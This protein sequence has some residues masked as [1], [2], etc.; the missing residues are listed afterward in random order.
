MKQEPEMSNGQ[1]AASRADK[2]DS[3]R[4]LTFA[5]VALGAAALGVTAAGLRL[6]LSDPE[7][8]GLWQLNF[9][10]PDGGKIAMSEFQGKP[11]LLNFWATW[12]P[13][14]VEEMPL[15]SSFYQQFTT[16]GYQMLGL[17]I[18]QPELVQRFLTRTPVSYP[19]AM[20]GLSGLDLTRQLGNSAGGLPFTVMFDAKGGIVDRKL[21]Q[22][23]RGDLERWAR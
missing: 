1:K 17:A 5:L 22:L 20:A 8:D 19:I 14:C 23:R 3:G 12:C 7:T 4:R 6:R 21:G 10:T 16:N 11:L 15:L 18:D 13:P 9:A 2:P